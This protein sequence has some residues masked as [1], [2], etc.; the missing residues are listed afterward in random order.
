MNLLSLL[1]EKG[2]LSAADRAAVEAEVKAKKSLSDALTA[3]GLSLGDALAA[4]A[5]DYG[6]P[7]RVL[8][9]PPVDE[10]A[11]GYIPEESARHYKI[12]PLDVADGAL[13]VGVV[14]P[15][16]IE[17]LDA[18]QFISSKIG[19]PYK[20]Y[21]IS[22]EDLGRVLDAYKNL[23]GEVGKAL[24]EYERTA[25]KEAEARASCEG[26]SGRGR[27]HQDPRAAAP[28]RKA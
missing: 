13:E 19:M 25:A 16:N 22:E 3:H 15:D 18:L 2:L 8:G 23:S 17:A 5:Q 4:V 12:A 11:L 27:A 7:A 20:T 14:D 6:I 28:R 26:A 1:A 9:E 10:T 21:L 24:S